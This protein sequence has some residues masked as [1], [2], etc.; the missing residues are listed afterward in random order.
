[1]TSIA[2][3]HTTDDTE[4]NELLKLVA[5]ICA[6]ITGAITWGILPLILF[7]YSTLNDRKRAAI[8]SR[9]SFTGYFFAWQCGIFGW[10]GYYRY[11]ITNGQSKYLLYTGK[12]LVGV[13]CAFGLFVAYAGMTAK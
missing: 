7:L 1:M 12:V 5:F 8:Y 6:G 2:Q 3:Q 11:R 10:W 13:L 4:I 9:Q